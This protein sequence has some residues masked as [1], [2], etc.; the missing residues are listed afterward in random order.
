MTK[1]KII[2]VLQDSVG[3]RLDKWLQELYPHVPYGLI[4]KCIR[5]GNI[6]INGKRCE[7]N[8][9]LEAGQEVRIPP[10]LTTAIP[11]ENIS[12]PKRQIKYSRADFEALEDAVIFED[13][14]LIVLNK[15]QGLPTQGGS[16]IKK[17]LDALLNEWGRENNQKYYVVHRLDRDTT[18][19]IV[20]AKSPGIADHFGK[21]FKDHYM[22]KK[23][24]ALT[25]GVPK[26]LEGQIDAPIGKALIGSLEKMVVCSVEEGG[27]RAI[28]DY[29]V[30]DIS[31][32]QVALVEA[33]PLTG[34]THQI[35][36]HFNEIE[37]PILGDG[38]Y[39]GEHAHLGKRR[40]MKLHA[41]ELTI[42]M[43]QGGVKVFRASLPEDFQST[44]REFGL[45]IS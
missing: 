18:G 42:P 30:L 26:P 9:K 17:S 21:A 33:K 38:K 44:L 4:A 24:L 11:A 2:N 45:R 41:Y 14:N 40:T 8:D 39:G 6:R 37:C 29:R 25:V 15:P 31:S 12:R 27:S 36:V 20:F 35:R 32:K 3:K 23:Y 22:E 5:K 34:R 10:E 13:K 19:V 43:P 28:T 7:A 1:V 16:K